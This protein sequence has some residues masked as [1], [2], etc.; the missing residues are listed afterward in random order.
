MKILLISFTVSPFRGSEFSVAWNYITR[1][2]QEHELFVIYGS[3][4]DRSFEDF[5]NT[6]EM[7]DW[8]KNNSI[9][10]VHFIDVRI[11]R[12]WW[13][14]FNMSLLKYNDV[15][16]YYI[17]YKHWHKEA[18][19]KAKE[20]VSNEKI[21]IIHYLNPIGFKEPGFCW[22]IKEVPYVW[23]PMQGVENRPL[24]LLKVLS[25]HE[26]VNVLARRIIH[27]AAFVFSP[28]VRK[29]INC[30]DVIFS[31][32]PNTQK[33]LQKYYAKKSVYLPENG[34]RRMFV[35]KPIIYA[36]HQT[37]NLIWVGEVGA[38]KALRI[39]I[40]ALF[41]IKDDN[42]HLDVCG[43]GPKMQEIERLSEKYGIRDKISFKGNI[44][45]EDVQKYF[46][47]S[48]LHI[49]SSLGEAT[50]TVLFEAMAWGVPTMTLDHCGMSG[51]VCEKCGIKIPIKSY[52]QVTTD[53]AKTIDEIIINPKK[54][55]ILSNGVLECSKHFMWE[56]RAKVFSDTYNELLKK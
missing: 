27:N 56:N 10:N 14:K 17:V 34:I 32:T 12:N 6:D 3:S 48:H 31:A 24:P 49:I 20:I 23:G 50:T 51:V 21:D 42:W 25:V 26:K 4:G 33:M 7:Q 9:E 36:E 46:S 54:I 22:K 13:I 55:G 30:A 2:S 38:R 19:R 29:A 18:Y 35:S 47:K 5:G 1:M 40:D 52:R 43:N 15:L 44:S 53:M 37:L 39:L 41:I 11:V 8:L 28:R 16:P 45:R